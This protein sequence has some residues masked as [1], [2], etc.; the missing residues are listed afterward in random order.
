MVWKPIAN[1]DKSVTSDF[2][3]SN[4]RNQSRDRHSKRLRLPNRDGTFVLKITSEDSLQV[5]SKIGYGPSS[6]QDINEVNDLSTQSEAFDGE[7]MRN[8]SVTCEKVRKED[9]SGVSRRKLLHVG[10]IAVSELA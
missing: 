3:H 6:A 10:R 8:K 1:Q 9:K 7:K 4:L 5:P 2:L